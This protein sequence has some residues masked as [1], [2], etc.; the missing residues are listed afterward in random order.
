MQP[1]FAKGNT[2]SIS[3]LL[4]LRRQAQKDREPRVVLR[5]QGIV[6]SLEGHTTGEIADTLKVHRSTVPLWINATFN[7]ERYGP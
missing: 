7:Q 6:M 5:I 3:K 4:R 2:R 1:V